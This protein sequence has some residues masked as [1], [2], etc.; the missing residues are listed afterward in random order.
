VLVD[1]LS[2]QVE[3]ITSCDPT[4]NRLIATAV[5]SNDQRDA[6]RLGTLARSGA[7]HPVFVPEEP[8]RTLR[9][10]VV[11]EQRLTRLSTESMLKVKALCR[12][13]LVDCRG[14]RVYAKTAR[15]EVLA[16][17]PS[18]GARSLMASYFRVMDLARIE[19]IGIQRD[20][21]AIVKPIRPFKRIQTVPGV[22]RIVA[23]T[24]LAWLVDPGRFRTRGALKAYVGLGLKENISN[25]KATGRAHASR[26]C[27]RAVKR[28]LFLAA[29]A[30]VR[31]K[32]ALAKR[33]QAR[34]AAGW[35]DRKAIRDVAATLLFAVCHVWQTGEEYSDGRVSVPTTSRTR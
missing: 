35:P 3:E 7:L 26:R 13:H 20:I 8:Y 6:R 11:H 28:V 31:G 1:A 17:M 12:R 23:W 32:N 5:D 21:R 14:R 30:A 18:A 16:Q 34:R 29:R 33:Y 19:R 27:Q 9:S 2:G 22:G 4:R 24:F 25:W 10:V 15:S